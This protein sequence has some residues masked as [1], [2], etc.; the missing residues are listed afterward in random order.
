M[1]K[2]KDRPAG[3][4][5][6]LALILLTQCLGAMAEADTRW[7]DAA[8]EIDKF[9]D[10]A[11]EDYLAGDA[12]TA[13][14]NVSNAYFRVY[15]TTG[16]ERQTMSYISG[17]RKNA[18]EMQ[19]SNCKA[20][21]KKDN[22][23]QDTIVSVRTRAGEAEGHDPR[24]RQQAGEPAGRRAER[25]EVVQGRRA[26]LR[27][28]LPGVFRRPQRRREVRKLVRGRDAGEGAAGH[29]LHGLSGQ[30]LH[31][32]GGQP[33]DR[34]LQRLRGIRPEPQDLHRPVPGGPADDGEAVRQPEQPGGHRRRRSTRRTSTAP[35]PTRPRTAY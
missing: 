14:Q 5:G 3:A 7:A 34:L 17:N 21:V 8:D 18:V 31:R 27:R 32:R 23:E 13:Y 2:T 4:A 30:G 35:P 20:A 24:G 22:A 25:D 1:K 10:T 28:P 19:F 16:F 29:G 12:D 26:G 6:V 15:E 11:F 9:L 33:G